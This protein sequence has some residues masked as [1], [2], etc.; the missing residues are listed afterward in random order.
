MRISIRRAAQRRGW[1]I[2]EVQRRTLL[3][4]PLVRRYWYG[5]RDGSA[6]GAPLETVTLRALDAFC[7]V[8]GEP[9][10]AFLLPDDLP[11]DRSEDDALS[12]VLPRRPAVDAASYA[13]NG[14]V[15]PAPPAPPGT[16]E[17]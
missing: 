16:T 12:A 13:G 2:S 8:F 17:A 7:R 15:I 14:G 3:P 5:T 9:P 10:G 1:S 11:D 6:D 4:M